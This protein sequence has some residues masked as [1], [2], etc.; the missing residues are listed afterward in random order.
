MYIPSYY[1]ARRVAGSEEDCPLSGDITNMREGIIY[2]AQPISPAHRCLAVH[3]AS[4]DWL[5][6]FCESRQQIRLKTIYHSGREV[7]LPSEQLKTP[8]N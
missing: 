2:L 5:E 1:C 7:N 4:S 6:R 8:T 3:S